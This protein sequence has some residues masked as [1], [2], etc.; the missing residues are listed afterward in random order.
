MFSRWGAFVYRSRR[1]FVAGAVV[2][3]LAMGFFG[4]NASSHLSSGGWL[5]TTSESAAGRP[6][7]RRRS[8][9]AARAASSP[10]SARRRAT[11]ATS[12]AFQA[13]IAQTVAP[14]GRGPGRDRDRRLCPDEGH[15]ASSAPTGSATY[16]VIQLAAT[17][18]QSVDLV[19]GH[20]GQ[21]RRS[22]RVQLPAD[23]L[24][25]DHEGRRRSCP[26]RTS[27][28]PRRSR[29]RSSPSS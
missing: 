16:V 19:A 23:R 22:G 29:C 28:G 27:P 25:A 1:V 13:A 4:L 14:A 10:S 11:D 26:R 8:S 15:R 21:A 24:R 17:D 5:D 2:F 3:A 9:G 12:P 6:A 18:E 20:P 7:P